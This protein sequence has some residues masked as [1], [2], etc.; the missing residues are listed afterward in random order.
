M[1]EEDIKYINLIME[2]IVKH[3]DGLK[4]MN[5]PHEKAK[6][7]YIANVITR[8]NLFLGLVSMTKIDDQISLDIAKIIDYN[9]HRLIEI[10]DYTEDELE[11]AIN[12]Q[13]KK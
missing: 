1:S 13:I 9:L 10:S 3:V 5:F 12:G 2:E 7:A 4:R 6:L 11:N 8:M